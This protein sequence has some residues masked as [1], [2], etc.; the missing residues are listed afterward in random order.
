MTAAAVPLR[1][2]LPRA[3]GVRLPVSFAASVGL[4]LVLL[5]LVA[6]V[7][8]AMPPTVSPADGPARTLHAQLVA[9]PAF[10]NEAPVTLSLIPDPPP[11]TPMLPTPAIVVPTRITAAPGLSALPTT[12]TTLPEIIPVGR[13]SYGSGDRGGFFDRDLAATLQQRFPQVPARLPRLNGTLSVMYPT[14]AAMQGRSKSLGALL[15]I[16]DEGRITDVRVSPQDPDFAMAILTALR[17]ARFTPATVDG[18]AVPYWAVMS[19]DFAIDGPTGPDG[20]PLKH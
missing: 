17:N 2:D 8:R 14:K 4:H 9:V 5:T 18:K 20:R 11:P 12:I 10:V 19:F 16:D 7:L 13:A 1:L 15:S 3:A 6:V